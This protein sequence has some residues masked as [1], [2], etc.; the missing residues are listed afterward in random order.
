METG[1]TPR[2]LWRHPAPEDPNMWKFMH[3]MNRK[4]GLNSRVC[5]ATHVLGDNDDAYN[6]QNFQEL[7]D[8]LI[9][10]ALVF[11]NDAWEEL[12]IIYNGSYQT[13]VNEVARIDSGPKWFVS[14]R[15]NLAENILYCRDIRT[16]SKS[17]GGK[18]D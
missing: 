3:T 18:V 13:V 16:V 14:V 7:Y 1:N 8:Y 11:Q 5:L 12:L 4:H 6:I 2:E 9:K 15:I 10:A 17:I